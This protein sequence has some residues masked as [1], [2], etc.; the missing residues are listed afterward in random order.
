MINVNYLYTDKNE[1]ESTFVLLILTIKN[2]LYLLFWVNTKLYNTSIRNIYACH[3]Q[4]SKSQ[5]SK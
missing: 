3:K 4:I 1:I 5:I 2:I